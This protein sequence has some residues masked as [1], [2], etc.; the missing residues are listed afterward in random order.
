MQIGVKNM[1]IVSRS[2]KQKRGLVLI[3]ELQTHT[4]KLEKRGANISN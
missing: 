3:R 2:Y 1:T 4:K